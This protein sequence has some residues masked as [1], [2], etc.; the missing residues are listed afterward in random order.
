MDFNKIGNEIIECVGGEKNV[1]S[2]SYCYT[3]L[4]FVLKDESLVQKAKIDK[5]EG[6]MKTVNSVGQFQVVV[7]NNVTK[8]YKAILQNTNIESLEVEKS[9]KNKPVFSRIVDTIAGIFTPVIGVMAACGM[10]AGLLIVLSKYGFISNKGGTYQVLN[11]VG[12]S[13]TYFLPII[14]AVAASKKFKTDT[15]TSLVIA[16]S[17]INPSMILFLATKGDISFLGIKI[18]PA[19]YTS[20]VIPIILSIWVLSYVEKF[21]NK[22]IPDVL[23][24]V[25]VPLFSLTIM[26]PAILLGFGPIGNL[27]ASALSNI[28]TS[29]INVS[30]ILAGGFLGG[31]WGVFVMFGVHRTLIP[32]GISDMI[33]KGSTSLFAFTGMTAF[34]QAGASFGVSFKTK[35][36]EMKTVATSGTITGLLG[37]SEP[38]IYAVNL[39]YKKPMVYGLIGACVGGMIVGYGGAK[40]YAP[41]MASILT[42]PIFF[43]PGFTYFVIG[44]VAAFVVSFLLT[45]ILGFED[46]IPEAK[47]VIINNEDSPTLKKT[48]I[49]SPIQGE[50]VHLEKVNDETFASKAMGNGIAIIPSVGKVVAPFDCEVASIFPT[51]HAIG[52]ISEKGIELMIHIGIDTV[53]LEGKYFTASVKA[54]DKV[55]KGTTLIEFDINKIKEKG[56]EVITPVIVM[57]TDNYLEVIETDNSEVKIGDELIKVV[58]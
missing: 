5:I 23:K 37:I 21:L 38:A 32:I 44:I 13:A 27:V 56:F 54:G 52:L 31:L 25:F 58:Q 39:K 4:R 11:I 29:I 19:I 45:V 15:M 50:C 47:K 17:L 57:N 7:G 9:G 34:A 30:P 22:I 24:I 14:L 40:A 16:A 41:G 26:V 8:M 10:I 20:T 49:Y 43:G 35:D 28:Y 42:L 2:L 1:V 55:K 53:K 36:K 6:V 18:I 3:R 33:S 46:S 12:N 51:N 48:V